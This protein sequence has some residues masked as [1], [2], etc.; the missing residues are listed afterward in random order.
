MDTVDKD[1]HSLQFTYMYVLLDFICACMVHS[2]KVAK[3]NN[4]N[5]KY[6]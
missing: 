3:S 1:I 6:I 4:F 2:Y 5:V